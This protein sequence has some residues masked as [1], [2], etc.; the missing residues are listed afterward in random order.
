MVKTD[1][2][3]IIVHNIKFDV[4]FTTKEVIDA[5]GST[6]CYLG[7][8]YLLENKDA[9][10]FYAFYDSECMKNTFYSDLDLVSIAETQLNNIIGSKIKTNN[11]NVNMY[12]MEFIIKLCTFEYTDQYNLIKC[13]TGASFTGKYPTVFYPWVVTTITNSNTYSNLDLRSIARN[14]LTKIFE[15]CNMFKT[16]DF[17]KVYFVNYDGS[18]SWMTKKYYTVDYTFDSSW[19]NGEIRDGYHTCNSIVFS[20]S[21]RTIEAGRFGVEETTFDYNSY[22]KYYIKANSCNFEMTYKNV[23]YG[24]NFVFTLDPQDP[25]K[26]SYMCIIHNIN[27]SSNPVYFMFSINQDN[28]TAQS[29]Y[30]ST[31]PVPFVNYGRQKIAEVAEAAAK[32]LI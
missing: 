15:T 32:G 5:Q 8:T 19:M 12:G 24:I 7:V 28:A 26:Y 22:V 1:L 18:A 10:V 2:F 13:I 23:L 31:S 30:N 11:L 21:N 29:F 17:Y 20:D 27:T 6:S 9:S 3:K 14:S 16:Y 25:T 4:E